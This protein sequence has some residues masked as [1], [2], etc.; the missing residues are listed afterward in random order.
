MPRAALISPRKARVVF[1]ACAAAGLTVAL[2][3]LN[4]RATANP[5][6]PQA[7]R[8]ETMQTLGVMYPGGGSGGGVR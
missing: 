4:A 8:P 7:P 6:D 5:R 2:V 1:A 3:Y